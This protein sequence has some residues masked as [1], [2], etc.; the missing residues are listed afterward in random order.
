MKSTEFK[1][2]MRSIERMS[3]TQRDKL[4]KRLKGKEDADE[5]VVLIEC[6]SVSGKILR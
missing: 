5:V 1:V 3:R 4:R 2:W 6:S